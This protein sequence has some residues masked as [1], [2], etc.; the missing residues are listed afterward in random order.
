MKKMLGVIAAVF[1]ALALAGVASANGPT[2]GPEPG[3][4]CFGLWRA[5][6]VQWLN[7]NGYGPVGLNYF[8]ERAGDN[9][10]IN[11]Q[12]REECGQ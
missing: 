8:S 9:A 11:A 5:G 1:A 3:P 10:A 6:S 2:N 7:E 4:G 12:N